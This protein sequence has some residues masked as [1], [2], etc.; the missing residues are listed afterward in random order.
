MDFECP[1]VDISSLLNMQPT[2]IWCVGEVIRL[3]SLM[4]HKE[5]G[6]YLKSNLN[7]AALLE[8]HIQSL[9]GKLKSAEQ[10]FKMLGENYH[11]A[12]SCSIYFYDDMPDI[13]MSRDIIKAL[14]LIN[15]EFD[16]DLY[17]L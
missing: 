8:D 2:G 14:A 13:H 3:G 11:M 7:K 10:Q 5:N 9:L 12:L 17:Q 6:W 15:C 4:K 16:L 1:H